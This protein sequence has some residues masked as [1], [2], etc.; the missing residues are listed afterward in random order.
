MHDLSTSFLHIIPKW[1]VTYWTQ[2]PING[3]KSPGNILFQMVF[4]IQDKTKYFLVQEAFL[5]TQVGQCFCFCKRDNQGAVAKGGLD[6]FP[7]RQMLVPDEQGAVY[8]V[9]AQEVPWGRVVG[10]EV[11]WELCLTKH[12]GEGGRE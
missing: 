6:E 1:P 5:D 11:C 2:F 10:G 7:A 12:A 9:E 4:H 3:L 8:L